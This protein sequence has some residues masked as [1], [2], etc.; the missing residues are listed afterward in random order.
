VLQCAAAYCCA[1]RSRLVSRWCQRVHCVKDACYTPSPVDLL[2]QGLFFATRRRRARAASRRPLGGGSAVRLATVT[3][4]VDLPATWLAT[5]PLGEDASG[6]RWACGRRCQVSLFGRTKKGA[7]IFRGSLRPVT[8]YCALG[9]L[10]ICMKL[11]LPELRYCREI[12]FYLP[13]GALAF[14]GLSCGRLGLSEVITSGLPPCRAL[15]SR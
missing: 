5:S 3:Q 15:A 12:S 8:R 9:Q 10:K 4:V 2:G 7:Q 13:C 11:C 14:D 6:S 1:S